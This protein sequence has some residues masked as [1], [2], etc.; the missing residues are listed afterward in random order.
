MCSAGA[1]FSAIPM[2]VR[3]PQLV[4][5]GGH[6]DHTVHFYD[7]EQQ[8]KDAVASFLHEGVSAGE[9]M[10]VI[11]TQKHRQSFAR[12]FKS[13]GLNVRKAQRSGQLVWRDARQTLDRCMVNRM[14]DANL[15]SEHVGGLIAF[16]LART[17]ST[18]TLR[19]YGE[20]VDELWRDGNAEA[21]LR[22][23]EMW[24]DLSARYPFSLF[25]GYDMTHFSRESDAPALKAVCDRHSRVL[26]QQLC[27]GEQ[28]VETRS[29]ALVMLQQRARALD[30]E[31]D[32]RKSLEHALRRTLALRRKAELERERLVVEARAARSQAEY[33]NRIKDEF[34]AVVSHE[35]RTP[36][37]AI[38]GWAQII[39]YAQA[40][41]ST[42]SRGIDVIQRN[43]EIQHQLIDELL[44]VSRIVAGEI[45]LRSEVIDLLDIVHASIDAI[46][47]SADANTVAVELE[48]DSESCLVNGDPVRLQQ[49]VWNLL[50]NAVKFSQAGGRVVVSLKPVN[51]HATLL[52]QGTVTAQ[53]GGVG[54]GAT[55]AVAVPLE[56]SLTDSR[57][58]TREATEAT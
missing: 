34:L 19:A 13:R 33:A 44:D 58:R 36:L 1:L 41:A 45:P 6:H 35:L 38:R 28:D 15:F 48:A 51:G 23:E 40:D 39:A 21:A 49:I 54:R 43:A 55:F 16:A 27:A 5:D 42:M 47:P 12:M 52:V 32:Q 7:N 2:D 8:L 9:P 4:N 14:P 46:G 53:S 56:P 57:G 31:I 25:C 11:A 30:T 17:R 20:I 50:S 26:P 37:T 22:L 29:R 3:A 18:G 24:N 10:V